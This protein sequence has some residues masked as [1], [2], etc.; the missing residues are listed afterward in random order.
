MQVFEHEPFLETQEWPRDATGSFE[1]F[2]ST[3]QS[4]AESVQGSRPNLVH[5]NHTQTIQLALEVPGRRS[6]KC[7]D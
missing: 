5:S 3:Q 6:R 1:N 7:A 2:G 4:E